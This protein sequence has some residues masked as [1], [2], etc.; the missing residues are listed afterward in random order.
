MDSPLD[1]EK[2]GLYRRAS[3]LS[4]YHWEN[5]AARNAEEAAAA[6]GAAVVGGVYGFPLLGREIRVD[7]VNRK[8]FYA[9]APEK[10]PGYQRALVAVAYLVGAKQF[11][12]SGVLVSPRELPA[13]NGFF[14]GPHALPTAV[15]AE[16]FGGSPEKLLEASLLMGGKPDP[17][18]DAAVLLPALPKITLKILLWKGDEEFGPEAAMLVDSRA[19]FHLPL[20]VLW[21]LTNVAAYGL[22][23]AEG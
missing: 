4:P 8:V 18:A 3:D 12:P 7:P 14:R 17:G 22:A 20:D 16:K 6:A 5:L 10:E 11:D 1:P 2:N 15:I 19:H 13:G 23:R 21:A 9:D